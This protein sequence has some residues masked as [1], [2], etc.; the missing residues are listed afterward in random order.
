M[1]LLEKILLSFSL[2]G[3]L[4][5][6]SC[7]DDDDPDVTGTLEVTISG[8]PTGEDANVRV[9]G[10]D[11]F[12][13]TITE[14]TTLTDLALG[15]YTLEIGEVNSGGAKYVSDEEEVSANLTDAETE[16]ISVTYAE[17]SSVNGIVGTWVSSG[18]NVAP[19]LVSLFGVDS[20]VA[21]F[22]SNQTYE[23][24]QYAGGATSPLTLTGTYSQSL[25]STGN[26]WTITV[27]QTT[28]AALTSEGIFEVTVSDNPNSMLYEIAQ[29]S[30][31]IGAIPATPEGGFGSTNGGAFGDTNIQKYIRRA[32]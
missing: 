23:V 22:N 10:P 13:E 20:I 29:T 24:L 6:S 18:A 5:I 27:D 4:L 9:N 3:I 28:P 21:T 32:F 30:P 1:K 17:F 14:S 26:I 8:L 12:S 16:S 19:I 25:S 15:I 11:G 7:N 31:D 2:V